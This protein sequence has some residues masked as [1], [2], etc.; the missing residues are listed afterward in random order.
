MT[1]CSRPFKGRHCAPLL[2]SPSFPFC[3]LYFRRFL[4]RY[5]VLHLQLIVFNVQT[6]PKYQWFL[7][8]VNFDYFEEK[9][10]ERAYNTISLVFI[11]F[12]P[13]LVILICY[14]CICWESF[15]RTVRPPNAT[16]K[17]DTPRVA[18]PPR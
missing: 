12:I 4:Y 3:R 18:G 2:D 7:Q 16:G 14:T 8:C 11:Y 15:H 5:F 9:W 6:H 1:K 13:L 17:K 10:Q